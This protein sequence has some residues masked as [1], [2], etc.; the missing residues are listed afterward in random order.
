MG[1]FTSL[2]NFEGWGEF[3]WTQGEKVNVMFAYYS[4]LFLSKIIDNKSIYGKMKP[5]PSQSPYNH[6]ILNKTLR[7]IQKSIQYRPNTQLINWNRFKT[8]KHHIVDE[9][10]LKERG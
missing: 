10:C 1:I 7:N 2:Y 8:T 5:M 4:V 6:N 3:I 9:G